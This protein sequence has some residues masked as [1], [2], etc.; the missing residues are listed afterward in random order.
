MPA[1]G[2]AQNDPRTADRLRFVPTAPRGANRKFLAA[3]FTRTSKRLATLAHAISRTMYD[4]PIST[5]KICPRRSHP[6]SVGETGLMRLY[7]QRGLKP[8]GAAKL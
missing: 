7:Q 6:V 2:H 4:E 5:H 8:L 1:P 3:A